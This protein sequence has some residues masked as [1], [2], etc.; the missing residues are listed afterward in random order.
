MEQTESDLMEDISLLVVDDFDDDREH[1]ISLIQDA[2]TQFKFTECANSGEAFAMLEA[3]SIDCV[4]LDY[5]LDNE[6]GIEVLGEI[7]KI[8]PLLPVIMLTGQ[9]TQKVAASAIKAGAADYLIKAELNTTDTVKAI[10]Q[11]VANSRSLPVKQQQTQRKDR[12]ES[13]S[14]LSAGIAHDLNNSLAAMKVSLTRVLKDDLSENSRARVETSLSVIDQIVATTGRLLGFASKQAGRLSARSTVEVLAELQSIARDP[15]TAGISL[16]FQ[17]CEED[18]FVFC[19]QELLKNALYNLLLNAQEA[20]AFDGATGRVVISAKMGRE[21]EQVYVDFNIADNGNGMPPDV[22]KRA[23]DPYFTTKAEQGGT[24]LGLAMVYGFANQ[25]DGNLI[26]KSKPGQGTKVT[27]RLPVANPEQL[28][29]EPT[30]PGDDGEAR[31]RQKIL[32]VEDQVIL[33]RAIAE[34]LRDTGYDVETAHDSNEAME[35]AAELS[36]LDVLVTD[37]QMPGGDNG[38]VLAGKLKK[39]F[40]DIKII[41]ISGYNSFE[42][43]QNVDEIETILQKPFDP[44]ELVRLIG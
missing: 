33:C 23:T 10:K 29:S 2:D 18:V 13:L 12:L 30:H 8:D 7:L 1:L 43:F 28:Q 17:P 39:R 38:F 3:M 36:N 42:H 26:F 20:I 11:A 14:H 37:I 25:S 19:D 5:R 31:K 40:Q 6:D 32:L 9:G 35:K 44:D 34:D 27:L 4:L 15:I 24:G 16:E 22:L 21:D 41:G